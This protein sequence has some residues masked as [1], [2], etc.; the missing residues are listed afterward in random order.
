MTCQGYSRL[1]IWLCPCNK[2]VN[3][4]TTQWWWPSQRAAPCLLPVLPLSPPTISTANHWEDQVCVCTK[5]HLFTEY[6]LKVLKKK[7]ITVTFFFRFPPHQHITSGLSV[8]VSSRPGHP[9]L[10]SYD[11]DMS[12][13]ASR[14]GSATNRAGTLLCGPQEPPQ[15]LNSQPERAKLH[16]PS[17][18][19]SIALR[20][21]TV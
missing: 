18:A 13:A 17:L 12:S 5:L 2:P 11:K 8:P 19:A 10:Q 15:S 14:A 9:R 16:H 21:V 20:Q 7:I 4:G 3:H 1:F 6:Y